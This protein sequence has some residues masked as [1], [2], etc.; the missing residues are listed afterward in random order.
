MDL[1]SL[2][3]G[4]GDLLGPPQEDELDADFRMEGVPM[5]EPNVLDEFLGDFE[6][7]QRQKNLLNPP[8]GMQVISLRFRRSC[9]GCW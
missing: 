5:P 7:Q 1:G 8:G 3:F 2:D 9:A 4:L 6:K